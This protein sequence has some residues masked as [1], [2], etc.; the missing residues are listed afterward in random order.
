MENTSLMVSD[1]L[2]PSGVAMI[3]V[4]KNGENCIVVASG[5][6]A[7]LNPVNLF[8]AREKIEKAFVVLMQLEI[9]V[10]TVEHVISVAAPTHVKVVL[11]PAPACTLPDELFQYISIITPNTTEAHMLCG[12]EITDDASLEKAAHILH[13][14]GVETVIITL[15]ARGAFVLHENACVIVEAPKVDTMDTTAAGDV[16]NGALVVSLSEGNDVITAT[17]F[18]CRAAAISVTRMGAQSSVPYRKEMETIIKN[19]TVSKAEA[20]DKIV[21]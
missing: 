9:P 12:I 13:A 10:A 6:N 1:P 8:N 17:K 15:G 11:N 21:H 18:A 20:T 7:T 14:K 19:K 16:F 3:T 2:N 4:D 5:S